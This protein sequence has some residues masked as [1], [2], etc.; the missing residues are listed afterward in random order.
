LQAT[1]LVDRTHFSSNMK[2]LALLN[3]AE[4]H[5]DRG[6]SPYLAAWLL[7]RRARTIAA[8]GD[9]SATY[10]DL[11]RAFTVLNNAK[12]P[13]TGYFAGWSTRWLSSYE[14]DCAIHLEQYEA[15]ADILEAL[16]VDTQPAP[17]HR[18]AI[19][20]DLAVSY[21]KRREVPRACEVLS[22]AITIAVDQDLR[23]QF[24]NIDEVRCRHLASYAQEPA[25]IRLNEELH[26]AS[27]EVF[28]A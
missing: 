12:S 8:T 28:P 21:A 9:Q 27:K 11:E 3:E 10:K 24:E 19:L 7:T 17:Y 18:L 5:V 23:E 4:R 2:A 1:A 26:T 25:V 15:S 22:R 14:A 20:R 6:S 13:A 16:L